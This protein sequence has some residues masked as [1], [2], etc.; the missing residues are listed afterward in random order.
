MR[1]ARH[2]ARPLAALV[3]AVAVSA[4]GG[5]A[6]V[7]RADSA[8]A[9]DLALAG[10]PASAA[11]ARDATDSAA[12]IFADTAEAP[13]DPPPV[14]VPPVP[15]RPPAPPPEP[16]RTVV[17]PPAV[18]VPAH[19]GAADSATV[20][21]DDAASDAA[22]DAAPAAGPRATRTLGAGTSFVV[23]T[24]SAVCSSR[25]R[26]GDRFVARVQ[27]SV[28]GGEG[29]VEPGTLVVLEVVEASPGPGGDAGGGSMR[30]RVRALSVGDS[31][32]TLAADVVPRSDVETTRERSGGNAG[33][34]AVR[35]AVIGAILGQVLGGDVRS[36][37][38]GAAAGA[39]V[40]AATGRGT[41]T[42]EGCFPAG[43]TLDVRL[44]EP[45][46]VMVPG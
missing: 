12:A 28:P 1:H 14:L 41:V 6:P 25:S 9:R 35:G 16:P 33:G 46:T 4:C 5:D 8:L 29:A 10:G 15:R 40:G 20:A 3:L 22:P 2:A 24:Q 45:V 31:S 23:A 11:A 36:T 21:V 26:P 19:G 44:T 7:G 30:F 37:A 39:A 13:M 27:G 42:Y 38:G 32:Y 43:G 18:S 34:R 17:A